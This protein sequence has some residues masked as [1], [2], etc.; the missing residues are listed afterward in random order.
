MVSPAPGLVTAVSKPRGWRAET[1]LGVRA[2]GLG[3]EREP[4]PGGWGGR[5]RLSC[6]REVWLRVLPRVL[7]AVRTPGLSSQCPLFPGSLVRPSVFSS[8]C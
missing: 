2:A 4:A 5:R 3:E 1:K 7:G 6:P 8:R